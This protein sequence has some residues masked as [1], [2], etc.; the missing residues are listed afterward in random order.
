MTWRELLA[1][2]RVA[3]EDTNRKEIADLRAV[4]HRNLSDANSRGISTDARYGHA[5]DAARVAAIIAVRASGYRVKVEGGG[6]YNTFKA[7]KAVAAEFAHIASYLDKCRRKR[8]D[9][10]YE[11]ANVVSETETEELIMLATDL[12]RSVENWVKKS[13][14]NLL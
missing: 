12:A 8:N 5:Y 9:F 10:L 1:G 13:H 2:G 4:V 3:K 11:E 14:P 6:H 7:F